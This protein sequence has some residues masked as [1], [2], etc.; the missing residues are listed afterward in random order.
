MG[1]QP[2]PSTTKPEDSFSTS[3]VSNLAGSGQKVCSHNYHG[4][5]GSLPMAYASGSQSM[6]PRPVASA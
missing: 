2:I 6:V 5:K 3:P 4:L 1:N